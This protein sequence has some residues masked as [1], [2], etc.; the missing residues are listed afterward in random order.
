MSDARVLHKRAG[1]SQ[2]VNSLTNLEYRVWTQ[3]LV[4]ADDFGVMPAT[5]AVIQAD[6]VYLR[7]EKARTVQA[8]I[9]RLVAIGLVADFEHQGERFIWQTDWQKWQG[10]R[11]PRSTCHPAPSTESLKNADAKTREFFE[12]HA[13]HS[14]KDFGKVSETDPQPAG[15]GARETLTLTQTLTQKA[16]SHEEKST[17][18]TR[19]PWLVDEFVSA[20]NMG[21]TPPIP[22]CLELSPTRRRRAEARIR[23]RP[24]EAQW[25]KIIARIEASDFCRGQNDRGWVATFDWLLQPDVPVKVL[26]G[27]YDNR[28]RTPTGRQSATEHTLN[29]ARAVLGAI[30]AKSE[31]LE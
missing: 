8:A 6:N 13:A 4:S 17:A 26:E 15:A 27:K 31:D 30:Q 7:R 20:W 29:A 24:Y 1:G 12:F 19:L 2:K 23:E 21:T 14:Q 3:Y 18:V 5:A 11:Y 10:I 22:R 9:E 25:L 28:E 16:N